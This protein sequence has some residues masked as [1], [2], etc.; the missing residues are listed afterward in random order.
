MRSLA[1]AH[2]PQLFNCTPRN[3]MGMSPSFIAMPQRALSQQI[4]DREN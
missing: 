3:T 1:G 2:Q 4:E